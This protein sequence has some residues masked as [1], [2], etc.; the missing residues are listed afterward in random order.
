V[1]KTPN[2]Q[3]QPIITAEHCVRWEGV[4][5]K[6]VIVI[7]AIGFLS[8]CAAMEKLKAQD[9]QNKIDA[10]NIPICKTDA[11]CKMAMSKAYSW[12]NQNCDMK[13][14]IANEHAVETFNAMKQGQKSCS[15]VKS[16]KPDG[17]YELILS[18]PCP[19]GG[20][21]PEHWRQASFNREIKSVLPKAE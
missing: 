12:V 1:R 14:Q 6:F 17:S 20:C 11:E 21:M 3:L 16:A 4:M 15:V 2:P 7:L 8:G 10:K 18:S 19:Y 13:V 5:K 9:E